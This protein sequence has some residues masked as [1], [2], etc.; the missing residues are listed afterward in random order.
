[1]NRIEGE[2]CRIFEVDSLKTA[3]KQL[4][5]GECGEKCLVFKED[6]TKWSGLCTKPYILCEHCRVTMWA[7]SINCKS[8]L[9]NKCAGEPCYPSDAAGHG[10][11]PYASFRQWKELRNWGGKPEDN[12]KASTIKKRR[13]SCIRQ[14][15]LIQITPFLARVNDCEWTENVT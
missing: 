9:A 4:W 5:C 13:E 7:L 2:R 10:R 8:V 1:M 6:S 14:V 15:H 12:K 11:P 3:L